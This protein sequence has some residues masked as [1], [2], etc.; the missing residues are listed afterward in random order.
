MEWEELIK[1]KEDLN[2][3]LAPYVLNGGVLGKVLKHPLVFDIFYN[4]QLHAVY[5][6][7]LRV[8]Q[9]YVDKKI[10][11]GNWTG[12]IWMYERPYRFQMFMDYM[13]HMKDEDYWSLLAEIWIDTENLWQYKSF[14]KYLFTERSGP[15]Q[16]MS[17]KDRELFKTLPDEVVV[18]RG[19]QTRN[20]QGHAWSL[21]PAKAL[22]FARRF[23]PVRYN[24]VRGV[25][26][27]E[28]IVA[29]LLRR[30]E[31]E[32]VAFPENVKKQ[33][34]IK[35]LERPEQLASLL[36]MTRQEFVLPIRNSYH[37]PEHWDRVERNSLVLC[38]A[39]PEA[40]EEVCRLFAICH[41]CKRENEDED[42]EHGHRAAQWITEH[43]DQIS[44]RGE[45]LDRLLYACRHHNDGTTCD[46]PTIGTCWDADRLDLPRVGITPNP[47]LLSTKAGKKLMWRV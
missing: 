38:K 22:W 15:R 33:Q 32:V 8:K 10:A 47:E 3:E 6:E 34:I 35:P 30:G 43:L 11:E 27:K 28:D 46:D 14:I 31:Y 18:Y 20:R 36:S 39:N 7:Q 9:E 44:V 42:P 37:G 2:P 23:S 29:V 21:S 4:E 26:R 1:R 45:R 41:D 12:V 16:M 19:Y 17:E 40:D 13:Q 24:V 25:V 5:N